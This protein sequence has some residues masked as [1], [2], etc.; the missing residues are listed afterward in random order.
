MLISIRYDFALLA[1]PKCASTALQSALEGRCDIVFGGTPQL[2]HMPYKA[3]EQY[4]IPL[5][6]EQF[7]RPVLCKPMSLFREP[8][9]WLFSWYRYRT[10]SKLAVIDDGETRKTYT[11]ELSFEQF[12]NEHFRARPANFARV[13]RQSQFIESVN[14]HYD[15]VTLYRY[16]SLHE[17]I[18][19]IEDRMGRRLKLATQN[20][21]PPVGFDLSPALIS[22]ARKALALEYEIYERIPNRAGKAAHRAD[23]PAI[24]EY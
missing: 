14:G 19:E 13:G 23:R 8:L 9:G 20:A 12:L 4:I 11:G 6:A 10:R 5:I 7:H 15:A 1:M 17:L 16:E 22:E 3:Y 2:K 18:A 21:S 24:D